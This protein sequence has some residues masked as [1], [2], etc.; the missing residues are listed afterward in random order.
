M[1]EDNDN[2]EATKLLFW[3]FHFDGSTSSLISDDIAFHKDNMEA[4][5]V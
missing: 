4:T 3:R 1:S 5:S 2:D